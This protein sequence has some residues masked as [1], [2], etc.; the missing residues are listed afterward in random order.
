MQ[1]QS[2]YEMNVDLHAHTDSLNLIM[3][4]RLANCKRNQHRTTIQH[5][6]ILKILQRPKQTKLNIANSIEKQNVRRKT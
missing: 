1:N 4:I 5:F 3:I 6:H 2:S